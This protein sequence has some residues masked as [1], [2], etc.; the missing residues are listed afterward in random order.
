MTI[1]LG[2]TGWRCLRWNSKTSV[3]VVVAEVVVVVVATCLVVGVV[4][5]VDIG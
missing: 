3:T 4:V 2:A 5:V 1:V